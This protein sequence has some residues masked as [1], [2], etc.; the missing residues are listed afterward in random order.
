[1]MPVLC[2]INARGTTQLVPPK[3]SGN[4]VGLTRQDG[5]IARLMMI[6]KIKHSLVVIHGDSLAHPWRLTR[7][8]HN[9]KFGTSLS[10]MAPTRNHSSLTNVLYRLFISVLTHWSH[11]FSC[12]VTSYRDDVM[13]WKSYPHYQSFVGVNW[14]LVDCPHKGTVMWN[15]DSLFLAGLNMDLSKQARQR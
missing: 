11:V 1:M 12:L 3:C 14:S 9:T 7:H 5:K 4:W 15:F 13:T 10:P 8:D 2:S 6:C